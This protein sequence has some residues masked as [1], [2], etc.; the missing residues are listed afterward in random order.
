M[1]ITYKLKKVWFFFADDGLVAILEEM[2]NAAMTKIEC[3]GVP[4]EEP[5]H[6]K[7]KLSLVSAEQKVE[8]IRHQRPGEAVRASFLKKRGK[9][10]DKR[11]TV[12]IIEKDIALFDPSDDDVLEYT[13]NVDA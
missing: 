9:A 13:G 4:S 5:S 3:N 1:D 10:A 2:T 6:E 12:V 7:R 8:M 11:I